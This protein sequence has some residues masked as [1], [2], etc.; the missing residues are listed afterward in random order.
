MENSLFNETVFTMK[1]DCLRVMFVEKVEGMDDGVSIT[2]ES[3]DAL[4]FFLCHL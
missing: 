2:K 3:E 4:L 1:M